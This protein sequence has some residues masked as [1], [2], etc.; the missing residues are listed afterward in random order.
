MFAFVSR[1]AVKKLHLTQKW[2]GVDPKRPGRF[3][4]LNGVRYTDCLPREGY[5]ATVATGPS[6]NPERDKRLRSGEMRLV[7]AA[8]RS[9]WPML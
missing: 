1:G 9:P 6:P 7:G 2:A 5:Q 3:T 8:T 4:V